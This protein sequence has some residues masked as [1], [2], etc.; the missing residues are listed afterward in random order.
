LRGRTSANRVYF[1]ETQTDAFA[2]CGAI[3]IDRE[4]GDRPHRDALLLLGGAEAAGED[5]ERKPDT[6]QRV[7]HVP[8]GSTEVDALAPHEDERADG[9]RD[10]EHEA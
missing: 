2:N 3:R 1:V 8:L 4:A 9:P 5:E 7:G 10:P 6:E